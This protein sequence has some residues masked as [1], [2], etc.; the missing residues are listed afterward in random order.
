M[1][2]PPYRQ[3]VS[4]VQARIAAGELRAGDRMPSIRRV[5][6]DWGV[7][8]ATATKAMAVLR[9]AGLLET[10]VGSGTVVSAR[11]TAGRRREGAAAPDRARLVRTA[12]AIADAEGLDAV[13]M[14]RLGTELGV[15]PM[16]LYRQVA[17]KDD[18]VAE[19]ADVVFGDHE[20]PDPGPDGWRAK[21][22]LASRL[23][24]QVVQRHPWLPRVISFTRPLLLP[25]AMAHTEW[26]LRALDGLGLSPAVRAREAITLPSLVMTTALTLAAEIEAEQNTGETFDLWW[27]A[28]EARATELLRG[29]AFPHLA[30]IP[31]DVVADLDGLFEHA[32]ARHLDGLATQV[33]VP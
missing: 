16:S 26:T 8:V 11:A 32:L 13:S 19:M 15:G 4:S 5:A 7:A 29:G 22:E 30:T 14:R 23:L 31:H 24:W 2:D 6:A 1:T 27:L 28:R 25:N 10:K 9:D 17:G 18:L 3:I 21:L 20:L 33:T 12:I